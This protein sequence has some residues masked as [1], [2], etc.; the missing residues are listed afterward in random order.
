[1]LLL[2][3]IVASATYPAE[4]LGCHDGDTCSFN[5]TLEDHKQDLGMGITRSIRTILKDKCVRLCGLNAPELSEAQGPG[6][7]DTLI[8][9]IAAAET[10]TVEVFEKPDK[11]GRLL[12]RIYADGVDLNARLI[13]EG[14][15]RP[16]I[17][18]PKK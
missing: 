8:A 10:V 14:R 17:E 2:S 18:C 15:A 4:F 7:R 9:W 3:L 1:M 12:G 5:L 11:Y 6:V 13:S 16:Y